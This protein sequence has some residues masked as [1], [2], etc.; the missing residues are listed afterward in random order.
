LSLVPAFWDSSA[1]VPLCFPEA[2]SPVADELAQQFTAVVWWATPVEIESA[3]ARKLRTGSLSN[4]QSQEAAKR[5]E[6]LATRWEVIDPSDE[7]LST[8]RAL[9]KRFDLR[10]ADGLQLAAAIQWRGQSTE[11]IVFITGDIRLANAAKDCG[12]QVKTTQFKP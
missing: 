12:F 2:G 11:N 6:K 3:L 4:E 1:L 9:L 5:F 8:A 10:A 7:V